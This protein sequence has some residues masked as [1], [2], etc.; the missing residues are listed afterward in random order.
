[1]VGVASPQF[2]GTASDFRPDVWIPFAPFKDRYTG[3][4]AR[5]EDRD[6]P[7]VRVY[8]RLGAG[9]SQP[10]A[11][12]GLEVVASGLD[13]AY[14]RQTRP[15]RVHLGRATWIDPSARLSETPTVRLMMVAAAVFLLLAC[16]NV[17]N[18]LLS[19]ATGRRREIAVRA[20]LGA[21]PGRLFRQVLAENVL[22][23][24]VAGGVGLLL[25]G[26][27]S[28]RL[29]SYFARP[30]VWGA[31]V[32]R[33][34]S[35]DLQV[36]AFALALS[37]ATGVVS[38]LMP[39][40]Q[41]WSPNLVDALKA[42]THLSAGSTKRLWGRSAPGV[43]D[44]LVA[45]QAG[46][47]VLLLVLAGLILRTLVS[48]GNLDPGFSYDRLVVTHISTS[49]TTLEATD[50]DRFF[51]EIARQLGDEPWVR[52]ATVADFPLLSQ[53]RSA[54]LRVEGQTDLVPLVYSKVLPGFFE[55]LDVGI[56]QGR[57]FVAGDEAGSRDVAVVN[58][59]LAR[60]FFPGEEP[61]GRRVWWPD[62][63]GAAER[64]FE[65]VGVVKD[66][67]TQDFLA[68]PEPTVYF[69]YPQ[70]DYPTGSALLVSVAG[71]PGASVPTLYRWLRDY[72]PHLAIVNVVPY[73]EVVRGLL[74]THRMNAEMFSGL[75]LLGL[76]LATVGVFSVVTLAVSRRT[77]EIG[78][79]M[80]LGARRRDIVRLV[81]RRALVPVVLG[82][83]VGLAASFGATGLVR[84]LLHGVEPNDLLTLATGTAVLL[85]AAVSAAC[86]PARRAAS[87]DPMKALRHE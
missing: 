1:V 6:T 41:A 79:R 50:R 15:R 21:S 40:L 67:K 84:S 36:L 34:A 86:L 70:H 58:E 18:L 81:L 26:P 51:R 63:D 43:S 5:A 73:P 71:D 55:T 22:L 11:R 35:L 37:L 59:S 7:L 27:A 46:L 53:H 19:L 13:E 25:A 4:A 24:G 9:V 74:Y 72:E 31:N 48:V 75:A 57:G 82:L 28:A 3:W 44:M 65:I 76:V 77:R 68:V 83:G 47:S 20:A 10:R 39:A 87:V 8:G 12:A 66:T 16:A 42:E 64:V 69:S 33:E 45:A 30:S 62:M 14:P 78:I 54:E 80:S 29:G 17:G 32:S 49:S 2:L 85:A 52:G 60:R 38:G 56:L 61:V 23:S